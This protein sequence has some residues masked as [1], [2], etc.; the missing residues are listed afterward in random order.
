MPAEAQL[1]AAGERGAR[2][3]ARSGSPCEGTARWFAGCV[4]FSLSPPAAGAATAPTTPGDENYFS[5]G[6]RLLSLDRWRSF[7]W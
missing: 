6:M 5:L 1:V 3:S 7:E 4:A 2:R